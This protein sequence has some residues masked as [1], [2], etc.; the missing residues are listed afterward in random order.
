MAKKTKPNGKS[1]VA[2]SVRVKSSDAANAGSRLESGCANGKAD[3]VVE[4]RNR[5]QL[6]EWLSRV[7]D[8][9]FPLKAMIEGHHTP[10]DYLTHAFFE[11]V[12]FAPDG[13]TP[14][15]ASAASVDCVVWA[16]RGGGKTFLG[17][18]AT[19]LD[20]LYKPGIEIRILAGSMDQARR[21]DRHLRRLVGL[22][23]GGDRNEWIRDQVK[24]QTDRR[25]VM[26][27]GSEV[28]LLAQSETSVRGT[29]VQKLRCDEV[30]LFKREV[31]E[32]AQLTTRSK[33]CGG[34]EVRGAV[35]C[36]STMQ[37]PYGIMHN[38]IGEA[39][40]GKRALFKWGVADVL[41]RCGDEHR[42]EWRIDGGVVSEAGSEERD[43]GRVFSLPVL[44]PSGRE[45]SLVPSPPS[46]PEVRDQPEVRRCPLFSEC[47]GRAKDNARNPGGH[48]AVSDAIRMK[49][50]VSEACWA[51]EML[52]LHPKRTDAVIPEFDVKMHVFEGE[53][54][55]E[56]R[57]LI[58]G[59]DFGYRA[60]T[61]ILWALLDVDGVVRVVDER[62]EREVVMAEH[63]G[64]LKAG[65]GRRERPWGR[66]AWAS[67]DPAG[68]AANSQTRESDIDLIRKAGVEVRSRR[69]KVSEGLELIRARL[70]PAAG[71]DG[72]PAR[73][74]LFIHRRCATLIE[75]LER[76]HYDPDRP[77][78]EAPV[79]DGFD[80]AVDALRYLLL[81]VDRKHETKAL[82][83]TS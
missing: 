65:R 2:R 7:L 13:V 61:V 48:I 37:R 55:T 50:R 28:E 32:A 3:D 23:A 35:E 47:A 83:Y 4:P 5:A 58:A 53:A 60:P 33:E 14:L 76:Y 43:V 39:R 42:C 9:R 52:C 69:S 73:P 51:S 82:S 31:W 41:E 62:S 44:I 10:L 56:N 63:V 45:I 12:R 30:E 80:H 22:G 34:K 21:M 26:A 25:I 11:G 40:A 72:A 81:G 77:Y 78:K 17:A 71:E 49:S 46:S 66:V 57:R 19:L 16:N 79:K 18:I 15:A 68:N 36:L 67:V 75:S 70:K 59:M 29:R 1:V 38:L 24:K 64:A 8:V 74:R 6:A 54:N 20:L 27:N